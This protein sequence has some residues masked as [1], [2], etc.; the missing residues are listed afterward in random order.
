MESLI[1]KIKF[2]R[3]LKEI[4]KIRKA[5]VKKGVISEADIEKEK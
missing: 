4:Q 5:L 1:K 2:E 3:E